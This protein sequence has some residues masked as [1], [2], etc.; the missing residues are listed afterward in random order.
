MASQREIMLSGQVY[1]TVDWISRDKRELGMYLTLAS[2]AKKRQ[3]RCV[4]HGQHVERQLADGVDRKG[5]T[6]TAMGPMSARV[7]YQATNEAHVAEVLVDADRTMFEVAPAHRVSGSVEAMLKGVVLN[8]DLKS[9]LLKTFLNRNPNIASPAARNVTISLTLERW[10]TGMSDAARTNFG[11]SI[12]KGREFIASAAV[13]VSHYRTKEG[14][15][16]PVLQLLPRWF[17]LQG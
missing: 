15:E 3:I 2:G 14:V 6:V 16:V 5:M 10:M 4:L 7:I 9:R 12:S 13:E 1:G 17:Q 8:W 11:T